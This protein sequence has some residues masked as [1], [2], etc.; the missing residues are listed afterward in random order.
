MTTMRT[1][2]GNFYYVRAARFIGDTGGFTDTYATMSEA[3]EAA[4]QCARYA[5]FK[6]VWIVPYHTFE[7][8]ESD[9]GVRRLDIKG[10]ILP[11]ARQN[12]GLREPSDFTPKSVTTDVL[13]QLAT[14]P[15]KYAGMFIEDIVDIAES[16][17]EERCKVIFK[18]HPVYERLGVKLDYGRVYDTC[19]QLSKTFKVS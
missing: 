9:F 7:W 15:D 18:E 4:N 3:R 19:L 10:D 2:L 13:A 6:Y 1:I 8:G 11:I 12:K 17:F 16:V 14:E 5:E